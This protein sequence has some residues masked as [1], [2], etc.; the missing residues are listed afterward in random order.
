M[1]TTTWTLKTTYFHNIVYF[2]EDS[3]K[4]VTIVKREIILVFSLPITFEKTR[5]KM[6]FK[7]YASALGWVKGALVFLHNHSRNAEY[8]CFLTGKG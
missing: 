3:L 4:C 5:H 2:T 7:G 8:V 1:D 6:V